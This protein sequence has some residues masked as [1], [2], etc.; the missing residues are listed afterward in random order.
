MCLPGKPCYR[1]S[2]VVRLAHFIRCGFACMACGQDLKDAEPQ[3]LTLDHLIPRSK[4][5]THDPR[6]IILVCWTCNV[7]RQAKPWREAYPGG[8]HARIKRVIRRK[9]NMKL[10]QAIL[11][12]R[13]GNHRVENQDMPE[14]HHAVA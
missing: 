14:E 3:H 4:G 11:D 7:R 12:G 2:P 10:A 5:G 6:N 9:L 1:P 8:A 13:T